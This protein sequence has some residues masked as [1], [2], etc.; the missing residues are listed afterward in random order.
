MTSLKDILL[1]NPKY[2]PIFNLKVKKKFEGI[3]HSTETINWSL[4]KKWNKT[5]CFL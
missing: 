4:F 5:S 3:L 1:L 2:I